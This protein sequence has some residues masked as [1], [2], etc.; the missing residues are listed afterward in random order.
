LLA[1]GDSGILR[2][3]RVY[4]REHHLPLALAGVSEGIAHEGHAATLPRGLE[5]LR[6]RGFLG[7]HPKC[8]SRGRLKMYQG[9]VATFGLKVYHR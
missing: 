3:R 6:D 9:S 2:E 7:G 5:N 4:E 8:T 1:G